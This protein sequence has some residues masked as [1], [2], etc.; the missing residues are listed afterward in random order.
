MI[1]NFLDSSKPGQI[2]VILLAVIAVAVADVFLKKATSLGNLQS[3]WISPWLY[4]AVGLYLFQIILFTVAFVSGW[5][6]SIVGALQTALYTVIVLTSGVLFYNEKL[7]SI[8][9][10]GIFLSCGGVILINWP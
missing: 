6:L 4:M 7:T 8:Q 2:F 10:V 3:V 9:L 5:K 1:T